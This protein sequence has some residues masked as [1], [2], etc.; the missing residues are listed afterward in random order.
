MILVTRVRPK[1]WPTCQD[2]YYGLHG[3]QFAE[4][5]DNSRRLREVEHLLAADFDLAPMEIRA[6]E[7]ERD[8]LRR[9]DEELREVV[10]GSRGR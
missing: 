5:E 1:A 7:D 10:W 3:K 2:V 6:L 4:Y 9:R 8:E